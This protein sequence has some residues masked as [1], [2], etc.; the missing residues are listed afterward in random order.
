MLLKIR[1]SDGGCKYIGKNPMKA[2]MHGTGMR[3]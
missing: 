3:V 2:D 1:L